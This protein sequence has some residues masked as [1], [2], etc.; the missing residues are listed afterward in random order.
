MVPWIW[1][2]QNELFYP[3]YFLDFLS[4]MKAM[5]VP[6]TLSIER[7]RLDMLALSSVSCMLLH[8][9]EMISDPVSRL[10]IS[11]FRG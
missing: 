6:S 11:I 2:S 10:S 3:Y 9:R 5:D 1:N 4:L 7:T 8:R